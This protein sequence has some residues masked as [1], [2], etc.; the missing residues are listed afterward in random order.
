MI[1]DLLVEEKKAKKVI[2]TAENKA[3][4]LLMEA[5]ENAKII[6]REAA[7]KIKIDQMTKEENAKTLKEIQKI[8]VE[9]GKKKEELKKKA[10]SHID[11][12]VQYVIEEVLYVERE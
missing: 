9:Y 7:S 10:K 11:Q 6:L 1:I 5:Q 2:E 8:N 4:D 3:K 12:A